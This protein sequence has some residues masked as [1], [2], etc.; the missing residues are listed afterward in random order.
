MPTLPQSIAPCSDDASFLMCRG[1]IIV[2]NQPRL[3]LTPRLKTPHERSTPAQIE[4]IHNCSGNVQ[5]QFS[6]RFS[7]R[8][9]G[10][11]TICALPHLGVDLRKLRSNRNEVLCVQKIRAYSGKSMAYLKQL[12]ELVQARGT[13][14]E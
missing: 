7:S 3:R 6:A 1:L 10:T 5:S 11:T 4:I 12:L 2:A 8:D 13:S 14:F 9:A